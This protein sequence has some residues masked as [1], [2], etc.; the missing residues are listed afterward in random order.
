MN[1]EPVGVCDCC[2]SISSL[3]RKY[4]YYSIHCDCCV[5]KKHFKYISHC[6]KCIPKPPATIKITLEIQPDSE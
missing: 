3:T 2:G 5:G 4:Y 6:K 1:E